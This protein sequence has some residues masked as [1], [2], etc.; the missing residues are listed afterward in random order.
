MIDHLTEDEVLAAL[1][2]LTRT[3]LVTFV[4]TALVTPL[5][6]E[7]QGTSILVFRQIDF[8][9]IRLLC[10]L[11]DDLDLDTAALG[12]VISLIDQLHARRQEL[13]ALARAIADEPGDVR[14][15]IGASLRIST[16]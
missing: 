9:R 16:D 10:D 5:R 8:A 1:P 13:L 2:G 7:H 15:R 3:R 11:T 4:E 6:R 14:A 12:V